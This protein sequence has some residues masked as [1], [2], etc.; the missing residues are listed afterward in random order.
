[1]FFVLPDSLLHHTKSLRCFAGKLRWCDFPTGLIF[2]RGCTTNKA[3][4]AT[5]GFLINNNFFI[6]AEAVS[7]VLSNL[8][9]V[10]ALRTKSLGRRWDPIFSERQ[11]GPTWGQSSPATW[12]AHNGKV[13]IR[14]ILEG[15]NP[16]R[17]A[18]KRALQTI[19]VASSFSC[20]SA[21]GHGRHHELAAFSKGSAVLSLCETPTISHLR[22]S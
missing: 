15:G 10:T 21:D 22:Q 9:H 4:N 11:T 18:A 17:S 7:R 16:S 12:K 19:E 3:L 13:K 20:I 1:M 5:S 8:Q 14:P 6:V 2:L